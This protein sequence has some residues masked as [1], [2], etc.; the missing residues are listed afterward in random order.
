MKKLI[1]TLLI[2]TMLLSTIITGCGNDNGETKK[3]DDLIV[4]RAAFPASSV[5]DYADLPIWKT[6]EEK[7]G[8]RFEVE[9][10][11]G[12]KISLMFTSGDYVDV[13]FS[14]PYDSQIQLAA[15]SGDVLELTDELLSKNAPTWKKFFDE[16][17]EFYNASKYEGDKLYS[18]PY[19]RTLEQ[20]R[21]VRDV[22]WIN[23]VWLDELNLKMPETLDDFINVLRAFRD[24]AGTGSIPANV[25]PWYINLN[26]CIGG[27]FDFLASYG[28]EAYDTTYMALD[29]NGTVVN[30]ATDTRLKSA[31]Q[32]LSSMY[33]EGLIAEEGLTEGPVKYIERVNNVQD[34]PYIGV[35]T[36]YWAANEEYVPMTLFQSIEGVEPLIRQQPLGVTRN[37]TVIF[38]KCK[39]PEKVLEIMDWLAQEDTTMIN[40]FGAEGEAWDY[41]K[42]SD[43]YTVHNVTD[44]AQISAGNAWSG[45]LDD[46]FKGRITF[47]EDHAWAKRQHAIEMYGDHRIDISHIMP[48]LYFTSSATQKK[49]N[50]DTNIFTNYVN[51]MMRKW[52]NGTADVTSDW[53]EYVSQVNALGLEDYISLYQEAYDNMSK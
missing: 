4:I 28:I 8:V 26:N 9:E 48:P 41:D 19:V 53:D 50:Y 35:F 34:T 16:N 11:T 38:S 15:T 20:D 45:M 42:A 7:F 3:G 44:G 33:A 24:N 47:D 6:I 17:P 5:T 10:M 37:R 25:M 31:M 14:A 21:G 30:Y 39:Y 36:A 43:T 29:G 49:Q 46:R 23:Q 51:Q 13:L 22:W 32:T 2:V 1:S 18:L 12:E 27:Q 52:I 40:E